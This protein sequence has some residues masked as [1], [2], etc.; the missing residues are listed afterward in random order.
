MRFL[1]LLGRDPE[2]GKAEI[3]SYLE[4]RKVEYKIIDSSKDILVIEMKKLRE[5]M[6]NELGGTIKIAKVLC[7]EPSVEEAEY[8]LN[9]IEFYK[10]KKNKISYMITGINTELDSFLKDYLKDYFKEIKVK[11]MFKSEVAP[12]KLQRR[13]DF[14]DFIVFRKHIAETVQISDL[15]SLKERDLGRPAVDFIKTTSLRLAKIL[16]NLSGA[17]E[18]SRF[19]DPF[20]GTGSVLQ[21]A[22]LLGCTAIGTDRSRETIQNAEK[23][24]KWLEKE[25]KVK[26]KYE[27]HNVDVKKLYGVVPKMS[28]E[29]VATEPYMGPFLRKLPT[30][31]E[32]RELV[33]ELSRLYFMTLRQLS[34]VVRKHRKIAIIIPHFRMRG[35]S[36]KLY[37]NIRA[38]VEDTGFEVVNT[39][40]YSGQKSKIQREIY[41]LKK[42]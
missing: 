1:F 11:A 35:S 27:L 28:I 17:K 13:E 21:E 16:V 40:P 37:I 18:G 20:C 12:G 2:I 32:A 36:K 25:Y 9:K 4:A 7:S 14:L 34:Q 3:E 38:M 8:Q 29:A 6:V 33:E 39:Y 23:N 26:N 10:G 31:E 22:L 5:K 42:V 19:L 30:P 15:E 41:V 24:L